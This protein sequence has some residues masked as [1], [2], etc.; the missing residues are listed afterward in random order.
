[1]TELLSSRRQDLRSA[2]EKFLQDRLN[3]RL[4]KVKSDDKRRDELR[5]Q[6]EL[7]TWIEDAAKRA[8]QLKLCH[9]HY[10]GAPIQIFR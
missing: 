2:L 9:A 3:T 6:Y 4:E 8:T 1:M 7:G 10:Q 5:A